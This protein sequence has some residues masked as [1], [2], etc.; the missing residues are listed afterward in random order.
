MPD[1]GQLLARIEQDAGCTMEKA[2]GTPTLSVGLSLPED[3]RAFYTRTGGMT[4][5]LSAPYGVEIVA[6]SQFVRANPII[7][8]EECAEDISH[9]WFIVG[10]SSEQYITIDLRKEA[11]GRCYDSFWDRHGVAGSCPV[12]A[13]SFSALLASLYEAKGQHWFWM[14]DDFTPLGDAYD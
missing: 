7:V 9:D 6:P 5:F 13:S 2:V 8:G 3:L 12:I 1:L 14:A 10:R 4:L 11:M